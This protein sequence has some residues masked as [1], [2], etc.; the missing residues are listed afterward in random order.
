MNTKLTLNLDKTVIEEAKQY[1]KSRQISLSK[2]I[3]TYL[4]SLSK[5]QHNEIEITPLVQSL[6][7]VIEMEKE[8]DQKELYGQ[9][10]IEKYK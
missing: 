6:S 5:P 9:Y 3:E 1:A 10:L 4:S 2:L 8:I 7:G